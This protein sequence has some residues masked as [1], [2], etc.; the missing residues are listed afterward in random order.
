MPGRKRERDALKDEDDEGPELKCGN[1]HPLL[2]VPKEVR[3]LEKHTTWACDGQDCPLEGEEATHIDKI[4]YQ[5]QKYFLLHY[6]L[7]MS[8]VTNIIFSVFYVFSLP[9][10]RYRCVHYHSSGNCNYD[11]CGACYARMSGADAG[12]GGGG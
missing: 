2:R 5:R 3:R 6:V 12:E 11:L 10:V 4:R 8:L 1:G 7:N 9:M